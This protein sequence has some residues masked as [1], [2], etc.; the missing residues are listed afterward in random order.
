MQGSVKYDSCYENRHGCAHGLLF[1]TSEQSKRV[2]S[3][4]FFSRNRCS[5]L[6]SPYEM[7]ITSPAM[8]HRLLPEGQSFKAAHISVL[9]KIYSWVLDIFVQVL[10]I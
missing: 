10:C 4:A 8:L 5:V 1:E 6:V 9:A 2:P 3:H 7:V